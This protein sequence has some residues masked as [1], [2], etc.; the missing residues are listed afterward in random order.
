[1]TMKDDRNTDADEDDIEVSPKRDTQKSMYTS[2]YTS[3]ETSPNRRTQA[4]MEEQQE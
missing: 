4:S 1:M 2:M 3:D